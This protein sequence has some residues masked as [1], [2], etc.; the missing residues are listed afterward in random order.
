MFWKSHS[1]VCYA[2]LCYGMVWKV[3]YAMRF[4]CYEISM[5]YYAMV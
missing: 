4:Q 5:L 3:W 1:M 2:I